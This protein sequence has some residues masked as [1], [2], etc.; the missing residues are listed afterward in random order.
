MTFHKNF[1]QPLFVLGFF[2]LT[3]ISLSA[4]AYAAA[5]VCYIETNGDSITRLNSCEPSELPGGKIEGNEDKCFMAKSSRSGPSNFEPGV[6]AELEAS[7]QD[8]N[9]QYNPAGDCNDCIS[10]DIQIAAN[11]L[12]IGVSLVITIMIVIA[13]LQ[14]MTS[15]DNPQAIQAAKTKI[16]NA[17]I[18]LIAFVFIY[19][20]LQWVVPGGI[21]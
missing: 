2:A 18:A 7:N 1:L 15:R 10:K 3:M 14:Y 21:F 12:A 9:F 11:V 8:I 4:P 19:A 17:V 6:C 20:F 16:I 5:P 13:G